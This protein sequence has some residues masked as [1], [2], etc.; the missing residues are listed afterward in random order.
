ME[1]IIDRLIRRIGE[2]G[3]P[4]AAGLDTLPDH[5]PPSVQK[6]CTSPQDAAAAIL[7]F[8]CAL[9]DR[10]KPI[11]PAVKVQ[12]ACYAMLGCAGLQ[13]FGR[14]LAC[15]RAAG[16]IAIA[17]AKCSD[18]GSTAACYSAAYLGKDAPFECDFLTLNP[19]LGSDGIEPFIKDCAAHNR[20]VFIL[21]KTSNPSS[22]QLQ[23]RR[24]DNGDTLC[25]TAG[26]LV[27]EWG[28]GLRGVQGYSC[29]GGV[30][31]AT[32]PDEARSLRGRLPHTFFLIPGYGAQGGSASQAACCFDAKGG[33]GI[34]NNSRGIINAHNAPRYKGMRFDEAAY[35]AAV[36]M[37]EDLVK[38]ISRYA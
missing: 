18:I 9:I 31:G 36:E 28:Q 38:S 23:D 30:V 8:N 14:T 11:V 1:K 32:H 27:E 26:A 16:L 35:A 22:H 19:Y 37:R 5:L 24:L 25:E 7:D 13:A 29:A 33:G 3:S 34:V 4:I 10:L 21:I 6:C 17:D 15:A 20:G 2:T 12:F